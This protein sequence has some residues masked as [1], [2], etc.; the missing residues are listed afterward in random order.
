MPANTDYK[1]LFHV[2]N[3]AQ[4]EYLVVGGHAV[5]FYSEPRYTKA[6]DLWGNP[7]PENAA[8]V[9][10]A[11][12]AFGAPLCDVSIADFTREE[13]IYQIGVAPSRIDIIMSIGGADFAAA[14]ARHSTSTYDG[15]PIFLIGREELIAAKRAVGR[16]QDLLDVE[17]LLAHRPDR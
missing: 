4:V 8:R 10:R 5:M 2:F 6:L 17:K 3:S 15:V 9:Y 14:F 16:Q 1:E 13:L 11:L 12:A 7:T